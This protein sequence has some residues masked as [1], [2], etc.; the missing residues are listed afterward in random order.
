VAT[1]LH[2]V[3]SPRSESY[4]TRLA[5]AFFGAYRQVR[6]EDRIET[7]DVFRADIPPFYAPAAKAK[8][9][10]MAGQAPRDEAEAAWQPVIRAINHFKRFDKYVLSSAMWNFGVPYRLKQ[11]IDVIVQPGYTFS[12]SPDQ[13][14]KGLVTGKPVMLIVARGGSYGRGS[15]A[16]AMDFQRPYL[17][18]IL[19]FIGF[20]EIETLVVEPTLAAGPEAAAKTLAQAIAAAREKAGTF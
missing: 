2:I 19:R 5:G 14:Y 4:S 11:Y 3:A 10:V 18:A 8:Y 1:I 20:T 12:F 13:G 15:G 16:E 6:P 9:A 7:L 17:D